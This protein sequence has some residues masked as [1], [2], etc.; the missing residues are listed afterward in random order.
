MGNLRIADMLPLDYE[1]DG[2]KT[3]VEPA[4]SQATNI[5]DNEG[6]STNEFLIYR[7]K[8]YLHTDRPYY[9]MGEPI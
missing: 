2:E 1:P 9:F 6:N 7:E 3:F 8:A 4:I 5:A